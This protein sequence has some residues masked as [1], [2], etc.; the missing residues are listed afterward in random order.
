MLTSSY[1]QRTQDLKGYVL[2]LVPDIAVG[3]LEEG[4]DF[5]GQLLGLAVHIW[6][7]F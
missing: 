4:L 5:Y 7:G 3:L 1:L 6:M 2:V